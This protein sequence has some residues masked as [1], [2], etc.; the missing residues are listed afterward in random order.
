M[1]RL[2]AQ[3]GGHSPNS[4][5]FSPLSVESQKTYDRLLQWLG[6]GLIQTITCTT[7]TNR[8]T[9]RLE[10]V[11]ALDLSAFD[12]LL[13]ETRP[14]HPT[15]K[16][17]GKQL[18]LDEKPVLH[19]LIRFLLTHAGEKYSKED[20][21]AQ[22][23]HERYNPLAHDARV[24]TSI[25]RIR[26]FLETLGIRTDL[27]EQQGGQYGFKAGIRYAILTPSD[28]SEHTL[29]ERQRWILKFA[30]RNGAIERSVVQK[31]MKISPTLAKSELNAL[32]L[33]G[34]LKRSGQG[35]ATQY[36]LENKTTV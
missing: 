34:K 2:A 30:A 24:Y 9:L 13:D 28:P 22:V 23:W 16:T 15:L 20:L 21:A 5:K 29:N 7:A 35:K 17:T 31:V 33:Q 12:L 19:A 27:L 26:E 32:I 6:M 18:S 10:E 8:K 3:L 36:Y 4:V 11:Q 25:K 1:A 14:S